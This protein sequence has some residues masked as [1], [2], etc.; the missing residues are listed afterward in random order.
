MIQLPPRSTR[1]DTLFPYPT[2][3]RS[4]LIDRLERDVA[5]DAGDLGG[6][7]IG[8]LLVVGGIVGNVSRIVGP[9]DAADAMLHARRARLHPGSGQRLRIAEEGK[10]GRAECRER[11]CQYV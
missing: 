1:T 7:R 11:V 2:L 8:H 6:A 9:L 5:G 3:F 4:P 10:L